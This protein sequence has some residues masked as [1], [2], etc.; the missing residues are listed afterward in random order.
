MYVCASVL[1]NLCVCLFVFLVS[2]WTC[3]KNRYFC[4]FGVGLQE[5]LQ[6]LWTQLFSES[7]PGCRSAE[8]VHFLSILTMVK[9]MHGVVGKPKSRRMNKTGINMRIP[10]S[11]VD[12]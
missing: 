10:E 5:V 8:G 12:S 2:K 1:V 11:S 4:L 7:D 3:H 9:C 6:S